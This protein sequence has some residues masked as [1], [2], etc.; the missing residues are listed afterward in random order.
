MYDRARSGA[1]ESTMVS[2]CRNKDVRFIRRAKTETRAGKINVLEILI[3]SGIIPPLPA[4][5]FLLSCRLRSLYLSFSPLNRIN[6]II[7]L[8]QTHRRVSHYSFTPGLISHKCPANVRD[9]KSAISRPRDF[10]KSGRQ[11][12]SFMEIDDI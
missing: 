8:I 4:F 2:R 7:I 5:L 9:H 11:P 12:I 10:Q 1:I 6:Q 3:E